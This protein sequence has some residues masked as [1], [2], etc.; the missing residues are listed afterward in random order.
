M[1][2]MDI[3]NTTC[4][5]VSL[6]IAVIA[7]FYTVYETRQSWQIN[8]EQR[9]ISAEHDAR[10][11]LRQHQSDINLLPLCCI[12]YNYD[13]H[14]SY[15]RQLYSDFCCLS[16]SVQIE[17]FKQQNEVMIDASVFSDYMSYLRQ[18]IS[19]FFP[20]AS[21]VCVFGSHDK[22]ISM[23]ILRYGHCAIRFSYSHISELQDILCLC[24]AN[25]D[26]TV[27]SQ[28]VDAF[29][30]RECCEQ[31][32]CEIACNTVMLLSEYIFI[33]FHNDNRLDFCF[34]SL[35]DFNEPVMYASQNELV[36][37]LFLRMLLSVHSN[38]SVLF[39]NKQFMAQLRHVYSE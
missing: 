14:H 1:L 11:F 25:K 3:V 27:F 19:L 28:I 35:P 18:A 30:F 38:L 4:A 23:A 34:D 20:D 7:L 16:T 13:A 17:V 36:E 21:P 37:D 29:N 24:I 9:H 26:S 10:M 2:M 39:S 12:A 33:E 15:S 8:E 32:A 31:E 5:I 6:F 22:Y